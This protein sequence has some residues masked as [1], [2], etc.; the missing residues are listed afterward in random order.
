MPS[1]LCCVVVL[2]VG[3]SACST[4]PEHAAAPPPPAAEAPASS[5]F[6][7][8]QRIAS[9]QCVSCH[10]VGPSGESPN[11]LAPPLRALAERYP[12]ALLPP[13][14][15]QRM[16]VGHPAMPDFKFDDT[17]IDALLEYLLALQER[18][19]A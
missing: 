1:R 7:T 11:E 6:A 4:P 8:G 10:A 14:F 17:E 18:Q 19:G 3:L 2:F 5:A 16:A 12:G 13:A 15:R 9:R